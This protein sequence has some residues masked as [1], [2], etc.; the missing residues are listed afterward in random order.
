MVKQTGKVQ[1]PSKYKFI[2]QL[3]KALHQYGVPSYKSE[4]YLSEI[5]A[6]KGIRASFMDLPTSINYV[7]YE[8]DEQTYSH[9]ES[10]RPGELNLGALS[11]IVEIANNLVSDKI[12][13]DEGKLAIEAI[14]TAPPTHSKFL[15]LLGFIISAGA[16]CI[17]L[18]TSWTS[19]LAA[20]FVGGIVY[21]I[22]LWSKHSVYIRSTLEALVAFVATFITGLLSLKFDQI[23][24]SMTILA[25][26]IVFIPG[27]SIT[28]ALEEITARN[29][30]SGTAKLFDALISLFK[31]FFGV[32]MGLAILPLFVEINQQAVINDIPNWIDYFAIVALSLALTPAFKIRPRDLFLC[33][34][35]GFLSF[36]TTTLFAFTGI[37]VSIFMGTILTVMASKLF[38]KLNN[39][40]R[41]V[42]LI[43]GIIMLVPGSKAFIGLSS[44]FLHDAS[45][46]GNMGEQVLYIFMGIIGGL[47]FSGTF[48]D[49][50][51]EELNG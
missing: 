11:K 30:V 40:P 4:M 23:N 28:T 19:A 45:A 25:S 51:L 7:F 6:K 44:V 9:A 5:A 46:S 50:K 42:Y 29:L 14:R 3:G 16:F 37:L 39:S 8:K 49:K 34:V 38:S 13:F 48:M 1:T 33:V 43:P 18:D 35:V 22:N 26:I 15:E 47:L 41:M 31:Q 24:I 20:S 17:I 10:L 12:N 32:V 2:V 36:Y 21:L 27:L